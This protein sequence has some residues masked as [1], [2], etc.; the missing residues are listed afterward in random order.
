MAKE[1][2]KKPFYQQDKP[3]VYFGEGSN[4]IERLRSAVAY[5]RGVKVSLINEDLQTIKDPTTQRNDTYHR[6]QR[7]GQVTTGPA[8]SVE[9]PSNDT[10]IW[11]VCF[12]SLDGLQSFL[13]MNPDAI[14]VSKGRD[15]ITML[16][17][18]KIRLPMSIAP[19]NNTPYN[20]AA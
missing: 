3:G 11:K 5:Q 14:V 18:L 15:P 16:W 4:S 8:N 20:R 2:S 6:N 10:G 1:E 7:H 17:H 19:Y 9:E 13:D 12:E